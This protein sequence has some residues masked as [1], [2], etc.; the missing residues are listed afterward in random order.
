MPKVMRMTFPSDILWDKTL[1]KFRYLGKD[2]DRIGHICPIGKTTAQWCLSLC[3]FAKTTPIGSG[4]HLVCAYDAIIN[5]VLDKQPIESD[6]VDIKAEV[7]SASEWYV[8]EKRDVRET[9]TFKP[10]PENP[11]G[12]TILG[13]DPWEHGLVEKPVLDPRIKRPKL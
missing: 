10:T 6:P 5:Q 7:A 1:L 11:W 13:S 4:M 9:F 2:T 8:N 12:F 3:E